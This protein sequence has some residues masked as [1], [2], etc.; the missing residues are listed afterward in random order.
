MTFPSLFIRLPTSSSLP[1]GAVGGLAF[2]SR[3]V[4][5]GYVFVAVRGTRVD[6]HDYV[7]R[8]LAAGAA[9]VVAEESPANWPKDTDA[10]LV[11]VEN[12]AEALGVLAHAWHGRPSEEL[13]LI[14]V[15]GTNGKTTVTTLLYDLYTNLGY[16]C[17]LVSTVELRIGAERLPATHTT[18]DALALN[19]SLA[20][21]RDAG[22]E[23][24][25][26][27]VSSHALVQGRT[28]GLIFRGGVFTNLTHDHLDYHGTFA[29]YITAKKMLFDGLGKKAFA[30]VNIDDKR[31]DVMVQN[32]AAKIY[33]YSLRGMA[34]FRARILENAVTGLHLELDGRE[35]YTR[36]VGDFNA[37]NLLAAYGVAVIL[38]E[39]PDRVLT[40]LSR[41]TGAEGRMEAV[42]LPGSEVRGVVDYAHT[43]DALEKVLTSLRATLGVG[44]RLI[45]VAGA[46]GDRDRSKRPKMGNAAV[47]LADQ[48]VLT[49]DNPRSEDPATIIEEMA[50]EF[51]IEEKVK[52]IRETD[53]RTAIRMAVRLARPGDVILVAGKGHETYQEVKGVRSP[54]DDRRELREA[55][56]EQHEKLSHH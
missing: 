37:Y 28:A 44:D 41:L 23:Y 42:S 26:M 3:E 18:P 1:A 43:P 8:A 14:G 29:A 19:A 55:L 30:L 32:T 4:K 33:R 52:T 2:D 6:G 56:K 12:S 49:S 50:A 13:V 51:G 9:V 24:V 25:F 17:G 54:F 47:R 5:P 36:M 22:C 10:A 48:V 20:R 46:G 31:G 16:R 15:T 34:D 27:E 53:R 21:M 45:C 39:E 40:E 11:L 35:V 38:E 7:S